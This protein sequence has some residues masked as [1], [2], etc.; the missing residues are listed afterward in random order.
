MV[1]RELPTKF[2]LDPYSGCRET[3][4][5]DDGRRATDR[6]RT[7]D[8]CAMTGALLTKSSRAKKCEAEM[9]LTVFPS[10]TFVKS[11]GEHL[12]VGLYSLF[13]LSLIMLGGLLWLDFLCLGKM[14]PCQYMSIATFY[15]CCRKEAF[16]CTDLAWGPFAISTYGSCCI[17]RVEAQ[18][19]EVIH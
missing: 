6:R 15:M 18:F 5:T 1:E 2:G 14:H 4:F 9:K 12:I 7:T 11:W 3:R 10:S 13:N 17:N 19:G 16:G 8:A